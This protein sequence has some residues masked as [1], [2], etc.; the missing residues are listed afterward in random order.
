MANK[1]PNELHNRI[2][3]RSPLRKT[4]V[5]VKNPIHVIN[6]EKSIKN[7]SVTPTINNRMSCRSTKREIKPTDNHVYK[8][9][10]K[11][12]I[13]NQVNVPTHEFIKFTTSTKSKIPM[14]QKIEIEYIHI[15]Y[16]QKYNFVDAL[17]IYE[18]NQTYYL[19]Y[20]EKNGITTVIIDDINK[21][22]TWFNKIKEPKPKDK[23]DIIE[24]TTRKKFL[25]SHR[26]SSYFNKD[27]LVYI[28]Y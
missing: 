28:N 8:V 25:K 3:C 18:N 11:T 16:N 6:E 9:I 12:P 5:I 13:G 1:S 15:N 24:W 4:N 10:T 2:S 23:D 20:I 22:E 7:I 14:P 21:I 19:S 17:E 26:Y 27:L